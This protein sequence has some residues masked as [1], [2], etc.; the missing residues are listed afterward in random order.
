M[1][2]V[3]APSPRVVSFVALLAGACLAGWASL[4]G[5]TLANGHGGL[6]SD[7]ATDPTLSV[8]T[9]RKPVNDARA[10]PW[11]GSERAS[12][13]SIARVRLSSPALAGRFSLA[14]TG[15]VDSQIEP[16]ARVPG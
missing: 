4:A 1:V 15:L 13:M 10:D 6:A 11:F 2:I 7:I 5:G 12:Q 3:L 8:V 16:L 9:T 14:A